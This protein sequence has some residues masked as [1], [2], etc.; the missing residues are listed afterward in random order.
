[1]PTF[2]PTA[3]P[4]AGTVASTVAN[5]PAAPEAVAPILPITG[6]AA[7]N[8]AASMASGAESV[9][10]IAVALPSPEP[11][12]IGGPV[13]EQPEGGI[14][15][16]AVI[17]TELVNS[18][19]GPDTTYPVAT[20]LGRGEDFDI[21]GKSSDGTWWRICCLVDLQE[22]WVAAEFADSD[23]PTDNVPV[24]QAGELSALARAR[25][26]G[27]ARV[28]A[29]PAATVA[30]AVAAPASQPEPAAVEAAPAAQAAPAPQGEAAVAADAPADNAVAAAEVATASDAATGGFELSGQESFPESNVV[31]VF[32]YVYAENQGLE[33]YSLR[34]TKDGAEQSVSGTSFGG[35][36]GMT[37]PIA[38]DRQR[39]QN[40][41][42]EFPSV[43]PA[44]V[45][46]V[47]LVRDGAVVGPAATFTLAE[48]DPA[49]ELYVRYKQN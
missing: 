34:V 22:V 15:P 20:V 43:A 23:G 11:Q 29:A 12:G 5:A 19:T 26:G 42:V 47:E 46:T 14:P 1:M 30:P 41:K 31:R 40:F 17:N 21:T 49:R 8:P 13:V 25:Q 35:Q 45:W 9:E 33:G 28:V 16:V 36:P 37:W 39:F 18:R 2:T 10:S 38:D 6:A 3:P 44:G 4:D 48:N 27:A 24:A 7:E 32:L